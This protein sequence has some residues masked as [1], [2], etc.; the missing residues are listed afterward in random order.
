[1]VVTLAQEVRSEAAPQ[2]I[3]PVHWNQSLGY[4]RQACARIYRDGGSAADAL[5]AFGIAPPK[6]IDWS[7]AVELLAEHLA[8]PSLRKAA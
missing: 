6:A 7:R 1:M 2:H 5:K 4:A 3:N 8:V